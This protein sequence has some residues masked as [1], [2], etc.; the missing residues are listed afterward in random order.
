MN[1]KDF[2]IKIF[3]VITCIMLAVGLM[4]F[5]ILRVFIPKVYENELA[6]RV[7]NNTA[8]F[9][10][11]L[12]TAT[13]YEWTDKLERF[14]YSNN[15]NASVYY[16]NGERNNTIGVQY[17]AL[18]DYKM[19]HRTFNISSAMEL[20]YTKREGY[21]R[22]I[23]FYYNPKSIEYVTDTFDTMFPIMFAVILIISVFIA[24]FYTRFMV[25]YRNLQIANEK[26]QAV[27]EDERRRR[28][29]FSAISHELKTPVTILKGELDGMI[30]GVGKFKDRDKY[31]AEAYKTTESVEKLVKEIMTAAKL[32]IIKITPEEISLSEITDD[33]LMKINELIN[34]KN[35]KIKQDFSIAKIS[36]DKKLM[37]IVMSN[38]IGNAVKHSPQGAEIDIR[39]DESGKF[40]VENRGTHIGDISSD[41]DLS[42]G[43]GLY[44]VKTIL[45]MH[46]LK[47]NFENTAD[48]T[49]FSINFTKM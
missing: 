2:S 39:F 5:W 31:L 38:I 36:A 3:I 41:S 30:L 17:S 9:V 29:F 10:K 19:K 16:E 49:L 27:I 1:K 26:L 18:E 4:V 48:G 34:E 13:R 20:Y 37:V 47:Y 42:G 15:I 22:I 45:D 6:S 46:G 35:I 32:D 23:I 43:L 12:E 24:F 33:C 25:K 8:D 28:S 11:E 7:K 14:C 40:S 21:P 44:I